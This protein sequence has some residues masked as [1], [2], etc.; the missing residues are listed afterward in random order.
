[1]LPEGF[2][3][4]FVDSSHFGAKFADAVASSLSYS[5]VISLGLTNVE[6]SNLIS[7]LAHL[8]LALLPEDLSPCIVAV[9]SDPFSHI[10]PVQ[11]HPRDKHPVVLFLE[12]AIV[13]YCRVE[14]PSTESRGIPHL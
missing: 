14:R 6:L 2:F 5:V 9:D 1:M 11:A 13:S 3:A 12:G 7:I 10:V 8:L 4:P